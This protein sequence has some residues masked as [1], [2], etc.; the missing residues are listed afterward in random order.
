ML[1]EVLRVRHAG[2]QAA[3]EPGVPVLANDVEHR[4]DRSS[5]PALVLAPSPGG[6]CPLAVAAQRGAGLAPTGGDGRLVL[7]AVA[8][9][10]LAL[11]SRRRRRGCA[12]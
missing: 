12:V 9:L 2:A 1:Q 8:C 11:V 10:V 6:G 7:P 5:P 3:G 4:L